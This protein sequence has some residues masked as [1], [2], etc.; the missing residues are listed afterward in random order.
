MEC[1]RGPFAMAKSFALFMPLIGMMSCASE[2]PGAGCTPGQV[3]ACP[4][5]GGARGTQTCA[6]NGEYSSCRCGDAAA[7]AGVAPTDGAALDGGIDATDVGSDVGPPSDLGAGADANTDVGGTDVSADVQTADAT[8]SGAP[9][10]QPDVACSA[11]LYCGASCVDT[12]TDVRHCGRCGNDCTALTGVDGAAVRCSGG[13]CVLTGACLP[14]RAHCSANAQDGCETDVTAPTRCG[15]C[16]TR[17]A[18]PAPLCSLLVDSAGGR[19]YA[20][21]SGCPGA[22]P[23]RCGGSC[24]DLT[25]DPAHCGACSNGC[26]APQNGMAT[27]R[28][29]VCGVTCGAGRHSCGAMCADD[30]S[31]ATCGTSCTPCPPP[32]ANATATC[33]GTSCGFACNAGFHNCA[34]ACVSDSAVTSC[35]ALCN[36][37]TSPANA[38]ATCVGG[39]C[40]FSCNS[41]YVNSA[42]ACVVALADGLPDATAQVSGVTLLRGRVA[43]TLVVVYKDIESSS[44]TSVKVAH[45]NGTWSATTAFSG[46]DIESQGAGIDAAGFLHLAI[47][48]P[49]DPTPSFA[50]NRSGAFSTPTPIPGLTAGTA[51]LDVDDAGAVHVTNN[52]HLGTRYY[53]T[54]ASGS[55]P[56]TARVV[57]PSATAPASIIAAGLPAPVITHTNWSAHAINFS[58]GPTW[59]SSTTLGTYGADQGPPQSLAALNGALHFVYMITTDAYRNYS[60]QYFSRPSGG[61]WSGNTTLSSGHAALAGLNIALDAAGVRYVTTCDGS[62]VVRVNVNRSGSWSAST[63]SVPPCT[64]A[65]DTLVADGRLY[66]AYRGMAGRLTVASVST[67]GL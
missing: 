7:D 43:G 9:D 65:L 8:D 11:G 52:V 33:N 63:P 28:A 12:S 46:Y 31:T 10:A 41:G 27:C 26:P 50:T 25:T 4:C 6:D 3:V 35:G 29:G 55:W 56:S 1:L 14:S 51:T 23:S 54:N 39:V 22:S 67:S 45:F 58:Q 36:P 15:D 13:A 57:S 17:C 40:G 30:S 48:R 24:V 34:G 21:V 38:N 18:E 44:R 16:S 59:G 2:E 5:L 64:G 60:V 49:G 37:C 62:G 42:G 32:P 61:S 19:R 66:M 20:C 47:W 53:S